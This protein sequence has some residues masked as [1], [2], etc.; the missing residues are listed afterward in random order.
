MTNFTRLNE[1]ISFVL[2][3]VSCHE[4]DLVVVT[5]DC[6]SLNILKPKQNLKTAFIQLLCL[7]AFQF[8]VGL[9]ST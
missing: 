8:I 5:N 1:A 7:V 4:E 2:N 3:F 9:K 6:S